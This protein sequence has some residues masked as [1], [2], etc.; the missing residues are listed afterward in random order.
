MAKSSIKHDPSGMARELERWFKAHARDLPWRRRRTRWRSLVSEIML[1]QTQV[2]RV[3]EKFDPFLKRFPNPAALASAPEDEVLAAWS[4][5]GYYR[6]ARSLQAAAGVI[7]ERHGGRVP[8]DPELLMALPGV[9]RYT[10]GAVA[11]IA[12]GQHVPIVDGNVHRVLSRLWADPVSA[13]DRAGMNR[14]WERAEFLVKEAGDPGVFNE[15]LMELGAC[16]CTPKAVSCS[17]CPLSS[18]CIAF[19]QGK[20]ELIPPPK[21]RVAQPIEHHHAIGLVRRRKLAVQKRS[22]EGR[23]GGMWEVPTVESKRRLRPGEIQKQLGLEIESLE[24]IGSFQRTLTHRRV[25]FHVYRGQ[26]PV[27]NKPWMKSLK[28][29]AP[30]EEMPMGVAQRRTLELLEWP[31]C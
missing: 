9:G 15:A 21:Q 2:S 27:G 30:G 14:A 7:V 22:T 28:W 1:Q 25:H 29:I 6:R 23:W 11:S 3:V 17:T 16:V 31:D 4:G 13:D 26:L 18:S 8:S 20:V 24:L 19:D 12:C 5:L 10:A